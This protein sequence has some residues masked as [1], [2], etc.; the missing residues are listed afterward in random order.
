MI[1]A[2]IDGMS[3][4][5]VLFTTV[6]IVLLATELGFRLGLARNRRAGSGNESQVSSMTGAHLGLLAFIL[7]FTFS[8]AAGHYDTR[9][10]VILEEANAIENAYLRT[11]LVIAPEA[12]KLK[13][14]LL[15]YITIRNIEPDLKK[16]AEA[17]RKSEALH[18]QMWH[19]LES[20]AAGQ[21]LNV[22]H[23]L[24]VQSINSVIDIHEDR[25]SAG[26]RNRIPP[27]IWVALY[28]VLTL[29]M[30][31]MGFNSGL[32]GSRSTVPSV[33]LAL[34]FSMVLY[35]IADLDRPDS[36]LVI[37]NQAA[38]EDLSQKMLKPG[39]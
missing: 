15:Q 38:M 19:E 1:R 28:V 24:L 39:S 17:I 2:L 10:K 13:S 23:S 37:S 27:S 6:F 26:L 16:A 12:D 11:S 4:T 8:M 5:G 30:L 25:V 3:L 18:A 14:L 22:M 33:A 32:Q 31:G 7:A 36:G 20:I 34:S 35:L 9:K 21:N 29:S